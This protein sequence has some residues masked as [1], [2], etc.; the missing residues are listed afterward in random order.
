MGDF[1]APKINWLAGAAELQS[2]GADGGLGQFAIEYNLTQIA[3][4]PTRGNSLFDIIF[5]SS[6]FVNNKVQNLAP[7]GDADHDMQLY[8][9]SISDMG[10]TYSDPISSI[11]HGKLFCALQQID[12]FKTFMGCESTG[13]YANVCTNMLKSCINNC[14]FMRRRCHL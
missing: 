2:A 7:M 12:W 4:E 3:S 8:S 6:N 10:E 1:N 9:F 5:I 11:D 13:D 14:T